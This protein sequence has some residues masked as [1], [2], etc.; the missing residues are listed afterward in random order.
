M[1]FEEITFN[2]F[3]AISLTG[4]SLLDMEPKDNFQ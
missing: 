3:E 4:S 2:G 1:G